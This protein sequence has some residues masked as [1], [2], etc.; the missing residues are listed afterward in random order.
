M[1]HARPLEG[2]TAG[3]QNMSRGGEGKVMKNAGLQKGG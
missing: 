1:S 3:V 2:S